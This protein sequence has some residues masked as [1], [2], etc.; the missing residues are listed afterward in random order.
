[1]SPVIASATTAQSKDSIA[2][3][4]AIVIASGNTARNNFMLNP[5]GIAK[6]GN[7]EGIP[8]NLEPIVSISSPRYHVITQT[9]N[10][11]TK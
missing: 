3:K 6:C 7:L 8:P 5:S 1:M 10:M 11:A 2:A 4:K 9:K